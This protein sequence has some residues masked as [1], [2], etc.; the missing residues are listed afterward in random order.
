MVDASDNSSE[1]VFDIGTDGAGGDISVPAHGFW[2]LSRSVNESTFTS[3][4][5]SFPPQHHSKMV[6][7]A[8]ILV[9]VQLENGD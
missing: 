1:Y 7:Q 3:G 2:V 4:F 6:T 8:C 9:Q 5:S